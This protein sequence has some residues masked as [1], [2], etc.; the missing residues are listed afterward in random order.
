MVQNINPSRL[1][2]RVHLGISE[3][4]ETPQG[5]TK[6]G[7]KEIKNLWC[8]IYTLSLVQQITLMGAPETIDLVLIIRH[9]KNGLNGASYARFK[10]KLYQIVGGSP[11]YDDSARSF[12]LINLKQVKKIGN[13]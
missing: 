11:D 2:Y 5:T 9:Q 13:A 4:V 10:D 6:P 12:D 8:G 7:F 3:P 1:N